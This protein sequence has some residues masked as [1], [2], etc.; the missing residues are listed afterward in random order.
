MLNRFRRAAT[1]FVRSVVGSN[2]TAGQEPKEDR[3]APVEQKSEESRP[4]EVTPLLLS[5]PRERQESSRQT[6]ILPLPPDLVEEAARP[7]LKRAGELKI[8]PDRRLDIQNPWGFD[9][10][11]IAVLKCRLIEGLTG[12]E[13]AEELSDRSVVLTTATTQ[14]SATLQAAISRIRETRPINLT[15]CEPIVC[16]I[17]E[18][19]MA[20]Q[21]GQRVFNYRPIKRKP[22]PKPKKPRPKKGPRDR[23]LVRL[24]PEYRQYIDNP[25]KLTREVIETLWYR[26]VLGWNASK[27]AEELYLEIGNMTSTIQSISRRLHKGIKVIR[28]NPTVDLDGFGDRIKAI[29]RAAFAFTDREVLSSTERNRRKSGR[30]GPN[31]PAQTTIQ[32]PTRAPKQASRERR[33]RFQIRPDRRPDISNPWSFDGSVLA[34]LRE[35]LLNQRSVKDTVGELCEPGISLDY[36]KSQIGSIFNTAVKTVK[37]SVGFDSE[38]YPKVIGDIFYAAQQLSG[39]RLVVKPKKPPK[40]FVEVGRAE[41]DPE[42]SFEAELTEGI[43]PVLPKS[44]PDPK[45]GADD[46]IEP[47]PGRRDREREV[48]RAAAELDEEGD[49]LPSQTVEIRSI[50]TQR[51]AK[52]FVKRGQSVPIDVYRY[53]RGRLNRE[54]SLIAWEHFV[55]GKSPDEIAQGCFDGEIPAAAVWI[56]AMIREVEIAVL[57]LPQPNPLDVNAALLVRCVRQKAS[58]GVGR[59]E[60]SPGRLTQSTTQPDRIRTL[61]L[62]GEPCPRCGG[63][64]RPEDEWSLKEGYFSTY[65]CLSCG[66]IYEPGVITALEQEK[67]NGGEYRQRR[68]QPS[69]GKIRL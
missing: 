47:I 32:K 10:V 55:K 28:A 56:S 33:R 23:L 19:V 31:P 25:W 63:A 6:I 22:V 37:V 7:H 20:L 18:G 57:G 5:P 41:E 42:G 65:T 2:S 45:P 35:R 15:G 53:C 26:L 52:F 48:E 9:G 36:A 62:A 12:K 24:K 30:R 46:N 4:V 50:G 68:R 3:T 69:H 61:Q 51:P 49:I 43:A 8:D 14:T 60:S 21:P 27:T 29:S 11:T 38:S 44:F 67:E 13:T 66:Y 39:T 59:A 16:N 64:M 58:K 34:I 40:G 17:Y 1:R 54:L